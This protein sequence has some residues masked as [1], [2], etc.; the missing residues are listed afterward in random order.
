LIC[1][2]DGR[3]D[4]SNIMLGALLL[5]RLD[6]A[7]AIGD[8]TCTVVGVGEVLNGALDIDGALPTELPVDTH[9]RVEP[10]ST[11]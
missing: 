1:G 10:P 8:A 2:D 6:G 9:G 4:K 7:L 11:T 5:R 3:F